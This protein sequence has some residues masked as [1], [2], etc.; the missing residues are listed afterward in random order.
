MA[1]LGQFV[2]EQQLADLLV[3]KLLLHKRELLAFEM[4]LQRPAPLAY[5]MQQLELRSVVWEQLQQDR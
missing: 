2:W 1:E 3:W 4:L 5:E